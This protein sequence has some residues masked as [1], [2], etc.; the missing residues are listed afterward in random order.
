VPF[1]FNI[2]S[3]LKALLQGTPFGDLIPPRAP[4]PAATQQEDGRTAALRVLREYVTQLVFYCPSGEVTPYGAVGTPTAFQIRPENFHI[5]WPDS[6]DDLRF[7]AAFVMPSRAKYD[8]IGLV[9]YIEEE[10]RDRYAPGTVLQWQAEYQEVVNLELWASK[11]PE[12]RSMV[13]GI[14]TAISPTEQLSGIRFRMPMYFNEL[15]CFTLNRRE[16]Y[17][18]ADA[19]RGARRL[20]LEIEMRFTLVALVNADA[21]RPEVFTNVDYD[22]DTGRR[23]FLVPDPAI[24]PP[25]NQFPY[26]ADPG[27]TESTV[28]PDAADFPA[29]R[30]P[31]PSN[32]TR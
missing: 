10:T 3:Q 24:P 14:E 12:L 27:A 8:P 18:E 28:P 13:A 4:V 29:P 22:A 11:M 7:P 25:Q 31:L 30:Y 19:A 5:D 26:P 15:V 2:K 9:A 6:I 16:N 1:P 17:G 21:F 20:Q 32:W 23:F